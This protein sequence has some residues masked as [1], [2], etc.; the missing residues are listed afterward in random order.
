MNRCSMLNQ[1]RPP[2]LPLRRTTPISEHQRN[3]N[4][5]WG[6]NKIKLRGRSWFWEGTDYPK[7]ER[8]FPILWSPVQSVYFKIWRDRKVKS[9]LTDISN[10][11]E[12]S[13]VLEELIIQTQ[14]E[15]SQSYDPIQFQSLENYNSPSQNWWILV[16]T[17]KTKSRGQEEHPNTVHNQGTMTNP[18]QL[19]FNTTSG[20]LTIPNIVEQ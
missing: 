15:I 8:K 13:W 7:A 17:K 16:R 14:N 12:G 3:P 5:Y 18:I 2:G 11:R 4:Q 20:D 6:G 1:N 19:Q 9:E 10:Y